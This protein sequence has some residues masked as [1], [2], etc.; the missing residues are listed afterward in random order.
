MSLLIS[1]RVNKS[2]RVRVGSGLQM[3]A[4]VGS[5]VMWQPIKKHSLCLMIT[6]LSCMLIRC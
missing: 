3:I 6:W 4:V 2:L 1:L 5:G